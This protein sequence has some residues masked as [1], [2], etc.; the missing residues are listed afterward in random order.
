MLGYDPITEISFEAQMKNKYVDMAL[1][2]DGIIR[3]L[4]EVKAAGV[5]LRDRHI[6]Q[7]QMYASQNNYRWVLLTNGVTWNLYHLEFEEG[8]EYEKAFSVDLREPNF[9]EA[10]D[11]LAILHRQ[12]IKK[13]E[14]DDYWRRRVAMSPDSLGKSLFTENV[15]RFIRTEIRK[16]QGL[17]V[18]IEDLGIALHGLFTAEAREL[19]GPMRIR[20]RRRRVSSGGQGEVIAP[21]G[22]VAPPPVDG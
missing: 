8:I 14:L 1:K 16:Q 9:D 3:L 2:T 7:A 12:A 11:K 17:L 18:D 20:K 10:A 13:G 21:A 6:E 22:V 4:I 19:M 15:L 5:T